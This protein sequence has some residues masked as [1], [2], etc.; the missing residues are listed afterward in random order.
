MIRC[1]PVLLLLILP[2]CN[3]IEHAGRSLS[4]GVSFKIGGNDALADVRWTP[5]G[6]AVIYNRTVNDNRH[7]DHE[8]GAISYPNR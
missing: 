4:F 1:I 3:F 7:L 8:D 2:A 6:Q 5:F